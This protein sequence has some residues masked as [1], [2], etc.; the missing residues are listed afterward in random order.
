MLVRCLMVLVAT[1]LLAVSAE[2]EVIRFRLT[3]TIEAMEF[4]IGELPPGI[5][6]GAPFEAEL[7][8]ELTTPDDWADDPKRGWYDMTNDRSNNYFRMQFG[9]SEILSRGLSLWVGND[10]VDLQ[11]IWELPGDLFGMR[12][13]QFDANF[14]VNLFTSMQFFWSDPTGAVF[15]TDVLPSSLQVSS[16]A[17]SEK[18]V[19]TGIP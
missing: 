15:D 9:E 2:G 13:S 1:A 17:L 8:Y 7:S 4:P 16:S 12:G 5:F 3:G 6:E 18:T 19:V 10:I 14:N 11:H